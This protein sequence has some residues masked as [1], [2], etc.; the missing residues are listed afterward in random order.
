MGLALISAKVQINSC[1]FGMI[2]SSVHLPKDCLLLGLVRNKQILLASTETTIF[3]G[4]EIVGIAL[5]SSQL[6]ALKYTLNKTH[7]VY[8]SFNDFLLNN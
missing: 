6:P 1:Y 7:P 2:L 5:N 3:C 8:Y 4:D